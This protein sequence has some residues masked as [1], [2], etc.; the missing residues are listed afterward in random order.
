MMM[1]ASTDPSRTRLSSSR[2]SGSTSCVIFLL[3]LFGQERQITLGQ[4]V[5]YHHSTA[6]WTA[7]GRHAGV[8]AALGEVVAHVEQLVLVDVAHLAHVGRQERLDLGPP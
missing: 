2:C 1:A 4:L 3:E 5:E 8:R 6:A 7:E